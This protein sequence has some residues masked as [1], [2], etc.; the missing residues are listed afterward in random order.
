[1]IKF[2]V[3]KILCKRWPKLEEFL[4]FHQMLQTNWYSCHSVKHMNVKNYFS[5]S[6]LSS[7]ITLLHDMLLKNQHT[8]L[9]LVSESHRFMNL[10]VVCTMTANLRYI[11]AVWSS[12]LLLP[13]ISWHNMQTPIGPALPPSLSVQGCFYLPLTLLDLSLLG[14]STPQSPCNLLSN[15][16][17]TKYFQ[18]MAN[19]AYNVVINFY[20]KRQLKT[21]LDN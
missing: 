17:W 4:I 5:L 21:F 10:H 18:A 19:D 20:F 13:G 2:S 14:Y 7:D 6:H 15:F 3:S 11:P 8:E 12:K 9:S 1:M 16:V